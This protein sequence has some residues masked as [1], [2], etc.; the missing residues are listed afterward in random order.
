[1][2]V[3]QRATATSGGATTI[4]RDRWG[5]PLIIP[6]EGGKPV[7]YTRCTTLVGAIEDKWGLMAWKQRQTVVGL[8]ARPDLHLR[9]A[10]LG[11]Q[12]DSDDQA[13]VRVWKQ[14][15][16]E[17]CEQAM[18]AAGSSSAATIGTALHTYA[19][20]I[21][22]GQDV[23][24]PREWAR[25][26]D[27]YRRTTTGFQPVAVEQFVVC[28]Q[29]RVGGTADR[30]L[31]DTDTGKL[32]IGDIK[33]GSI[34]YPHKMAMQ[35]AV[36]AHSAAY[37]PDTGQRTPLQDIDLTSVLIIHLDA[38]SGDCRLH[39]VDIEAGWE[40]VGL[41]AQVRAWQARRGL[42]TPAPTTEQAT[43]TATSVLVDGVPALVA[44][45][46]QA[47]SVDELVGLRQTHAGQ[48]TDQ[49]TA[50]LAARLAQINPS[51]A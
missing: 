23:T 15:M 44:A 3:D 16:D 17:V 46:L 37:D 11:P 43:A 10:S 6:P 30:V 51:V 19:E 2:T 8:A 12:P 13:A 49:H 42:T 20:L 35:L 4:P 27:N 28:D 36:Y 9:A 34:D 25:H 18:E 45:I 47:G 26:L 5:R 7:P 40:A 31:R 32:V 39:W 14:Q 21:D 41:A 33:T 50:L 48:W 1:M 22:Q 29:Y 24:P 38:G